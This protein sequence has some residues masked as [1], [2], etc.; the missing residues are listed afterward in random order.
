MTDLEILQIHRY[1]LNNVVDH[2]NLV[3]VILEGCM[4]F[5]LLVEEP[6]QWLR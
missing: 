3:M 5:I 6:S 2:H 1:L 4:H